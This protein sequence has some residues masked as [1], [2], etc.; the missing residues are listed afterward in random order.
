[1]SIK[2][3]VKNIKKTKM[4]ENKKINWGQSYR[5]RFSI[6]KLDVYL[7]GMR[8]EIKRFFSVGLGNILCLGKRYDVKLY[9]DDNEWQKFGRAVLQKTIQDAK[10]G[11]NRVQ[12]MINYSIKAIKKI[13]N[14]DK[15]NFSAQTSNKLEKFLEDYL[16]ATSASAAIIN[17][18]LVIENHLFKYA[19]QLLSRYYQNQDLEEKWKIVLTPIK[20]APL[21]QLEIDLLKILTKK[22]SKKFLKNKLNLIRKKYIWL[23]MRFIDNKPLTINFFSKFLNN[24]RKK[25]W[26]SRLLEYEKEFQKRKRE[27]NKVIKP[28]PRKDQRFFKLVNDYIILR[29]SRDIYR[30]KANYYG[31]FLYQEIKKRF[32][33]S[34]KDLL[35]YTIDELKLLIHNNKKVEKK[36]IERRKKHFLYL[37][38]NEK[39]IV[40]SQ[41]Q[42]IKKVINYQ[43]S[44]KYKKKKI[45]KEITGQPAYPGKVKGRVKI[46]N[47]NT[48]Y[49]DLNKFKRGEIMVTESTKP[50]YVTA[51]KR[52]KAIITDE[53]GITCHAAIV[54][55]EFK[56]PCI[57]GT[58]IATKVLKDGDLVEV[59]ANKG[60]VKILK[61]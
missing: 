12:Q 46:I 25:K 41:L 4:L 43:L 45:K 19:K 52:A 51:M 54:S 9:Y 36:E 49:Q 17:A 38:I 55:R 24:L 39:R 44:D 6:H 28:L 61:R 42:K 21:V 27:F 29:Q 18:P 59:D 58:K 57:V 56:I 13:D 31:Y 20:P 48:L 30:G 40:I 22:L 37:I 50:D 1:M 23:G 35:S 53:G 5:R 15:I 2:K 16:K 33:I 11:F 32:K 60:V 26:T 47:L 10:N 7:L 8:K 14:F 3:L 34:L